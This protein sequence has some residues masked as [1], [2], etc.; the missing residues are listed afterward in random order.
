MQRLLILQVV[1]S[2]NYWRWCLLL[3]AVMGDTCCAVESCSAPPRSFTPPTPTQCVGGRPHKDFTHPQ[4]HATCHT[5]HMHDDACIS[6]INACHMSHVTCHR[7]RRRILTHARLHRNTPSLPLLLAMLY[8]R[9]A[10]ARTSCGGAHTGSPDIVSAWC[11][12][13]SSAAATTLCKA[14]RSYHA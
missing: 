13:N 5:C 8:T 2:M 7:R 12:L 4:G 1:T 10:H 14:S 11:R 9:D 3:R 6:M